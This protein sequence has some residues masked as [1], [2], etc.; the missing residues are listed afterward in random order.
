M[1]FDHG[2]PNYAISRTLRLRLMPVVRRP[3]EAS[4]LWPNRLA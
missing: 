3:E 1:R 4:N 2:A